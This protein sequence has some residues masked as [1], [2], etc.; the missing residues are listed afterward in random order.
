[1]AKA[2]IFSID[3]FVAF[4]LVLVVLH[5]L[6]FLASIPS[7]YYGAM[8]QA[9]YLARDTLNALVAANS[10]SIAN[11]V[12]VPDDHLAAK[13]LLDQ[14]VGLSTPAGSA[15]G[16]IN[17][18]IGA[19]IPDQYGYSLE[20]WDSGT[21]NWSTIYDTA[22]HPEDSHNKAYAKL[23]STAYAIYFGYVDSGR[24]ANPTPF[25]Y[26]TCNGGD[27][28][29]CDKTLCDEP[30]S[31]YKAGDAALGLVRMTVYR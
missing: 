15:N 20:L 11:A 5:S 1:M 24:Y 12:S 9:N 16:L 31:L 2:F 25:C 17:L 6:V 4:T 18:T 10:S 30:K 27:Y 21:Q 3:A 29:L 26:M 8:Q 19:Q 13:T 14:I 7:S 28:G 23:K 22:D